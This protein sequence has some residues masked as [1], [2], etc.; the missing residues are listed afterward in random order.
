MNKNNKIWLFIICGLLMNGCALLKGM[1]KQPTVSFDSMTFHNITILEAT[2]VFKV[3]VTNP[4]PIGATISHVS[5]NLKVNNKSI[6]Q[7]ATNEDIRIR[8]NGF[9]F[10][11]LPVNFRYLDVYESIQTFLQANQMDYELTG[12]VIVGPFNIPYKLKG[13][14]EV[15]KPPEVSLKKVEISHM[16]F[17]GANLNVILNMKN[18]NKFSLRI[19]GLSYSIKISDHECASGTAREIEALNKETYTTLNIPTRIDFLKLGRAFYHLMKQPSAPYE[20][21]G[22]IL[23]KVPGEKEIELPFKQAGTIPLK[24]S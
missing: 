17:T 19:N 22:S 11:K 15:P 6:F 18:G 24:R 8:A 12:N 23:I 20:L 4:N 13:N 14:M 2:P 5:Y 7:T 21:D 16:N 9:D 3:K 10:V 1:A